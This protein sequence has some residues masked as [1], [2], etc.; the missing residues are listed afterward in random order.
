MVATARVRAF[1]TGRGIAAK[2]IWLVACLVGSAALGI[3]STRNV[4]VAVALAIAIGLAVVLLSRPESLLMILTVTVF[5]DIASVGGLT[6]TR[7]VAPLA[8]IVLLGAGRQHGPALGSRAPATWAILYSTWALASGL[9]SVS[10]IDTGLLLASLLIA[11][12]YLSAFS[13]F[14]HSTRDL[15]R[16]LYVLTLAAL[17][18]GLLAITDFLLGLSTSVQAG[19][20]EGGTGDPNLFAAYQIMALPL[21]LVLATHIRAGVFRVVA[22][23]S[24]FVIIG[25]VFT[26]LSRGGLL[27]FTAVALLLLALPAR[28]IF[29]SGTQKL[30]VIGVL[31]L[32]TAFA[33]NAAAKELTPRVQSVFSGEDNNGSGRL[34]AWEAGLISIKE[35]PL[36]GLGFGGFQSQSRELLYRTPGADLEKYVVPPRGVALH[37]IYIGTATELGLPGLALLLGVLI[38]TGR[39]FRASARAASRKGAWF[40]MHI[41]NAAVVSLI[42]LCIVSFFLPLETSRSIWILVGLSLALPRLVA[43]EE[44][45]DR[46]GKRPALLSSLRARRRPEEQLRADEG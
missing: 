4:Q 31:A 11:L 27:T 42:S 13:Q 26:S 6:V 30:A 21:V 44:T 16:V 3:A 22:Y 32:G 37:N 15:M 40:L 2:S 35:R 18:T 19:R 12:I 10:V 33:F 5:A 36:L 9:W 25:S 38:S 7:L 29:R 1:R 46:P 23:T 34:Y 28:T 20:A 41:S 24:V 8:L 39:A 17:A 43:A 45:A 14:L